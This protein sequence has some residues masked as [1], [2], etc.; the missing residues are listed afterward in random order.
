MAFWEK[1]G[2]E[3]RMDSSM[4]ARQKANLGKEEGTIMEKWENHCVESSQRKEVGH[5][6]EA[7][8]EDWSHKSA[9]MARS[10]ST[11]LEEN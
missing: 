9:S 2:M 11:S 7:H 1:V 6:K 3:G 10:T 4:E 8:L 5:G